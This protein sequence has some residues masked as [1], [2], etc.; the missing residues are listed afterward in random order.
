M[1]SLMTNA[2]D[3]DQN[4]TFT[5]LTWLRS[6]AIMVALSLVGCA[7]QSSAG[8][9]Q[10][11]LA[12]YQHHRYAEAFS[13]LLPC[14]E[15]GDTRAEAFIGVM[16]SS[17]LGVARNDAL[18]VSWFEKGAAAG[19]GISEN[20]L[21]LMY[22]D[23][24]AV[25][26]DAG[27]A[28]SFFLQA[29]NQG[30]AGAQAN[31]GLSYFRGDGVPQDYAEARRW[32]QKA[33]NQ[34]EQ[35]GWTGL[36]MVAS[37]TPAYVPP[38]RPVEEAPPQ[39]VTAAEPARNTSPPAS[40]IV[41][42][43]QQAGRD[44]LSGTTEDETGGSENPLDPLTMGIRMQCWSEIAATQLTPAEH[45]RAMTNCIKHK[46]RLMQP[47]LDALKRRQDARANCYLHDNCPAGQ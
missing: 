13:I 24:R 29:A 11:G 7:A 4:C 44:M 33:A 34:G 5:K 28:A 9:Y 39:R 32:F 40:P 41:A 16:Y 1:P 19:D 35:K 18:A 47:T 36:R 31:I 43:V 42:A 45:D 8:T 17:G 27:K 38:S 12:A 2:G 26:Q 23:G 20:N 6:V 21:G 46:H 10:D 3:L 14:A 15:R 22:Q 25:P 37:A 30:L